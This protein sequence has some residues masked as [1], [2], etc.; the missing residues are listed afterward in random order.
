MSV[1]KPQDSRKEFG[2][3]DADRK[4]VSV[5]QNIKS[6]DIN[7]EVSYYR[8]SRKNETGLRNGRYLSN[9]FK[10]VFKHNDRRKAEGQTKKHHSSSKIIIVQI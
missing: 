1:S 8:K 6:Q 4:Q 2:E 3:E 7:A 9:N 5:K 10:E